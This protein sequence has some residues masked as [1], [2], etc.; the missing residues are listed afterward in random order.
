MKTGILCQSLSITEY[1]HRSLMNNSLP[2]A[3][4][5]LFLSNTT[6]NS[7]LFLSY[8]S[9]LSNVYVNTIGGVSMVD[10]SLTLLSAKSVNKTNQRNVFERNTSLLAV[11]YFDEVF[12]TSQFWG[13]TYFHATIEDLPHLSLYVEFLRRHPNIRLHTA[14]G[15][16]Q[17]RTT[18]H[19]MRSL[20]ALGI[21]PQRAWSRE[22]EYC[23][24]SA[25]HALWPRPFARVKGSCLSLPWRHCKSL[26][27]DR[28]RQPR[29]H[30]ARHGP[31]NVQAAH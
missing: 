21:D 15:G 29:L 5:V 31:Q 26:L 18:T 28:T 10:N 19:V 20:A 23:L 14:L 7:K 2:K 1:Q 24:S 13:Y 25:V 4:F 27:R 17:E 22:G 12:V 11:A 16:K 9:V 8:V 3:D 30:R 6:R